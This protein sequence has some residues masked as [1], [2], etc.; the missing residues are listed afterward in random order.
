MERRRRYARRRARTLGAAVA[1][2]VGAAVAGYFGFADGVGAM[3]ER[4]AQIVFGTLA[5]LFLVAL[6]RWAA[7]P[8]EY[9]TD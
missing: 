4:A 3:A 8:V 9:E 7:I 5:V 2:L 6:V 1:L